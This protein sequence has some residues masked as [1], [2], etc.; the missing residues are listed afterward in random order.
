MKGRLNL[1]QRTMLRWR[2]L[3]PYNA[4]HV[5]RIAAAARRGGSR[6]P[7]T[8]QLDRCGPDRAR[9][10]PPAAALR[11]RAAGR[12]PCTLAVLA[13][14]R[15]LDD[16]ARAPRSSGSSTC[17][18]RDDGRID[19]FR[20]FAIDRR[21]RVPPRR[22]LRPFR[23]RRRLD[24]RAAERHRRALRRRAA[25]PLPPLSRYPPTHRR[26]FARNPLQFVGGLAAAAGDG[27][28]L[29][30]DVR[31]RYRTIED[32]HNAFAFFTL[33]A[34]RSTRRCARQPEVGRHAERPA[35]RAAAAGARRARAR[36][37]I[38]RSAAHELAVA[39][40]MNLRDAHRRGLRDA[41]SAS[42]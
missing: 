27:V 40:I 31:P 25:R 2:E 14:R 19:P 8:R 17:R 37:R 35:A 32:G 23:R 38:A 33:D 3:H 41:S 6:R 26:L 34:G 16:D 9:A 13:A 24:R 21:R 5:V 12:R 10:R 11:I 22:R 4:V 15:R 18:S 39:S 20:F 29:P 7:S 1:F 28:E 36:S 30:Q 42:S